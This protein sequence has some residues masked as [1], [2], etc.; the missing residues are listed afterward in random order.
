M[1]RG[2]LE[3]VVKRRGKVIERD[4]EHNLIVNVARTNMARLLAGE[5]EN[6]IINRVAV[7]TNG[8]TPSPDDTKITNAFVKPISGFTYPTP[9]S[10]RFDF[11]ILEHEANGL[12]IVEFGLIA[13]DGSLFAR[14]TRNG[15]VIEK[16]A[17]LEID[18]YWTILF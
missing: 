7:G 2:S 4:G 17:D 9:T 6:R 15:K 14:R 3:I 5:G 8:A 18:G 11:T 16:E 1:L 12:A 13:A 10:V